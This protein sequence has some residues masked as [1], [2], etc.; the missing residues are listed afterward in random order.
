MPE[1]EHQP[2]APD[3]SA[4][5]APSHR[6]R[7]GMTAVLLIPFLLMGAAFVAGTQQPA[8][9]QVVRSVEVEASP[10]AVRALLESPRRQP[11]WW[12]RIERIEGLEPADGTVRQ[13]F[14]DGRTAHLTVTSSAPSEVV[15]RIADPAGPYRGV[16]RFELAVPVPAVP[17]PESALSGTRVTLT[18]EARLGNPFAR[19]L[20]AWAGGGGTQVDDCLNDLAA[21]FERNTAEDESGIERRREVDGEAQ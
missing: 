9:R 5:P 4:G 3:P 20:V 6:A 10:G 15:W 12:R 16:W 21:W 11:D 14:P 17:K 7:L 13:V 8:T 1:I 19:L 18:E 2:M